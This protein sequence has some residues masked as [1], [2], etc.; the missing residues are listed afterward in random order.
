MLLDADSCSFCFTGLRRGRASTG[1]GSRRERARRELRR[2]AN[3][4]RGLKRSGSAQK[5]PCGSPASEHPTAPFA[6]Q[7]RFHVIQVGLDH[8]QDFVVDHVGVAQILQL[9]A[10]GAQRRESQP[11]FRLAESIDIDTAPGV[12]GKPRDIALIFVDE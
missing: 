3:R 1:A 9:V 4:F 12:R 6:L 7:Q 10:F 2:S 5:T 11:P 8:E